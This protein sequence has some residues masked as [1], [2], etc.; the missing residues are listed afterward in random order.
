MN[1]DTKKFLKRFIQFVSNK[2]YLLIICNFILSTF[3]RSREI[4]R[5]TMSFIFVNYVMKS[6]NKI[7]D[8]KINVADTDEEFKELLS[9]VDKTFISYDTISVK[10]KNKYSYLCWIF[11]KT[12]DGYIIDNI[13]IERLS[14]LDFVDESTFDCYIAHIDEN[15][16]LYYELV[17]PNL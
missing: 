9:S 13:K 17:T 10:S 11:S 1:E 4:L 6:S 14:M 7:Y 12:G 8:F 15:G 3:M 2:P 5:K 16:I